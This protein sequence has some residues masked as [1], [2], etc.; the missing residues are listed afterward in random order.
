M[1]FLKREVFTK[2]L[3]LLCTVTILLSALFI[4]NGFSVSAIIVNDDETIVFSF[5]ENENPVMDTSDP[6]NLTRGGDGFGCVGWGLHPRSDGDVNGLGYL[7]GNGGADWSDPGGYRLNNNDGVYNLETSTTYI[8]SFK[9]QVKS[10]PLNTSRLT[11]S[12]TSYVRFGYGFTGSTSGNTCSKMHVTVAEIVNAKSVASTDKEKG[13]FT[14]TTM[15]GSSLKNV[16]KDW[17]NLTFVFTTPDTF[18]AYTPSLGFFSSC[19]YGTDFMIDDVSVTK[20]GKEKGVVVLFDDYSESVTAL[21]GQIGAS[22]DL[23]ELTGKE[24]SHEFIGWFKDEAR[25]EKADGLHFTNDIQIIYSAWKAPVTVTFVDT[26]N[27]NEYSVTGLAGETIVYPNDPIDNVNNPEQ[28]WFIDWYTTENYENKFID[29]SFGYSNITVYSKWMS[30]IEDEVED[31]ENYTEHKRWLETDASGNV[32]YGNGDTFGAAMYIVSDDTNN[33]NGNVLK[34]NWDASMIKI[35]EDPSTYNAAE[36]Y[37]A[38]DNVA[39]LQNVS[40]MENVSYKITFD[41]YVETLSQTQVLKV[42]PYNTHKTNIWCERISFKDT[43]SAFYNITSKDK[44]GAWHKGEMTLNMQF[45]SPEYNAIFFVLNLAENTDAVVYFDNI[46]FEAVQPYEASVLYIA[47]NN[48]PNKLVVGKAG[49]S[50]KEYVPSF[51][52]LPFGGWFTDENLTREFTENELQKGALV[53]YGS[54][55]NAIYNTSDRAQLHFSTQKFWIN[56]PNG[57]VYNAYRDEYHLF[58]QYNP[59]D[60][61]WGNIS[62]GHAVSKDL[63]HWEELGLLLPF[64]DKGMK[65]SGCAVIDKNNT[66]G[67]FDET[68]HP[69]D[70]MVLLVTNWK[71]GQATYIFVCYSTDG[72]RTFKQYNNGEAVLNVQDPKVI[73]HEETQKWLLVSTRSEIHYSDNLLDWHFGG[74]IYDSDGNHFLDWEC[75]DLYPLEIENET[76]AVKWVF[77]AAGS[78]YVVGD[79]VVKDNS[80]NFYAETKPQKYNGDSNQMVDGTPYFENSADK[81]VYATQSFYN[82]KF[83][84][85]LSISWLQENHFEYKSWRGYQTLV[86]EQKLHKTEN[87]YVL[88]SYPVEE[89]NDLRREI[90]F[91]TQNSVVKQGSNLLENVNA[92]LCDIETEIT[93]GENTKEVGFTV[94][95]DGKNYLKVYYDVEKNLLVMDKQNSGSDYTAVI[96]A[97]MSILEGNKIKLRIVVDNAV[98]EVFG[99]DG[100]TPIASVANPLVNDG[101]S[102]YVVGDDVKVDKMVVYKMQSA[103]FDLGYLTGDINGDGSADAADIAIV[104]KIIAKLVDKAEAKNSS[105]DSNFGDLDAADLAL[106]KKI[107]AN[108]I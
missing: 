77:N 93:L 5:E 2:I 50:L 62:W 37:T 29:K 1:K 102:F 96:S 28:Y 7:H 11:N 78:W 38:L 84:R 74:Y 4:S 54:W 106:L 67:L 66:T 86:Y 92:L 3:S 100:E 81:S 88:F 72:G 98:L 30:E 103:W 101:M 26:L 33:R 95:S 23:P 35:K 45:V 90:L 36:R 22:V 105:V 71:E 80:Y 14:L 18:G 89:V 24:S 12:M 32:Y 85:R 56:D 51:G 17:Y 27:N 108:L 65:W 47:N 16:G 41:Y 64:D 39:L 73:W 69:E 9:L 107:V 31:F 94:R 59:Y 76:D 53:L 82:D 19:Y 44:D 83:G 55:K 99:N 57:L 61:Y 87:G 15:S 20:L 21:T 42:C 60:V 40:L 13:T 75:P 25:S 79:L 52:E 58:Y 34:L 46:R 6:N 97:P 43:Q 104:K 10:T 70:R 91:N 8:V 68:T 48:E 49:D 63:V